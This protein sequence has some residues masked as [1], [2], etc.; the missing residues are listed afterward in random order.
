M[1]FNFYTYFHFAV[2]P[3]LNIRSFFILFCSFYSVFKYDCFLQILNKYIK[4]FNNW[5]NPFSFIHPFNSYCCEKIAISWL[6]AII[7]GCIWLKTNSTPTDT[8]LH[9]WLNWSTLMKE[10]NYFSLFSSSF[11]VA[12]LGPAQ[13]QRVVGQR[14][15]Q[16]N[17]VLRNAK[18]KLDEWNNSYGN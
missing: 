6:F 10:F 12:H 1:Y 11:T 15:I 8:F 4:C 14:Q 7:N 17:N 18:N 16:C 5:T 9:N 13:I 3:Q 2:F